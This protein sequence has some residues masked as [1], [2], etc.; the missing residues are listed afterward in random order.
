[1]RDS[2]LLIAA[3]AVS[4]AVAAIAADASAAIKTARFKVTVSG[5]QTTNWTLDNTTFD[6]CIQGNVRMSGSGQQSFSFK[7][8]KPATGLAARVGKSTIFTAI[9]GSRTPGARVKGHVTRQGH[10]E[11]QR[12]SGNGPG[13]G[14]GSPGAPPPPAPDCG[15]RAFAGTLDL[16]WA[17]PAQWPGQPPVPLTPVLLLEGPRMGTTS[18]STMFKN[19]PPGGPDQIIPTVGSALTTKKLFGKAKHF[20]V[21]GKDTDTTDSNGFHADTKVSWVAKF[22]RLKGGAFK[23]PKPPARPQCADGRDN[24]GDGKIDFPQDPGCTS[25]TDDSE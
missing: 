11:S 7:S 22:T 10:V 8:T 17:T 18:F 13:C 23:P 4:L 6:P 3:A 16:R 9:T 5:T 24:N 19:C 12:L 21:R 20:T 15:K 1:M 14:S 2:R 25:P